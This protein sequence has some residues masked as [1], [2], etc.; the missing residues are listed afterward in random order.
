MP[1]WPRADILALLGVVITVVVAL[2]PSV[3]RA[4]RGTAHRAYVQCGFPRRRYQRWFVKTYRTVY[5]VYLDRREELDLGQVY[6]SLSVSSGRDGVASRTVATKILGAP[7]MSRLLVIGDPGSGKSTLLKAYG[8]GSSRS[9]RGLEGTELR[10]VHRSKQVAFFVPLRH[11]AKD[12]HEVGFDLYRY[13]VTEILVRNTGFTPSAAGAFIRYL[14]ERD[15]CVVLLDGLDEVPTDR[16][17]TIRDAI[18]RF[19]GDQT[20]SCP[21]AHSRIVLTCRRQNFLTMA[22]EWTPAFVDHSHA[23]SPFRDA[24]IFRY[25]QN[26]R[27]TF[28][29]PQSPET[30]LNAVVA[31]GTL[32]LHRIPLILAMS[33]GLF[34]SRRTEEVPGSRALLYRAMTTELL[35]RHNFPTDPVTKANEFKVKDKYRFLREFA[36]QMAQRENA[37]QDFTRA[38]ILKAATEIRQRL[39][40]VDEDRIA[41]MVQEIIKRAGLLTSVSEEGAFTFAHRSIQEYLAAEE[42]QRD[43]A[44]GMNF[45]LAKAPDPEWRQV[46]LFF[47]SGDQS[48]LDEFLDRLLT[49]NAEL[50]AHCLADADASD[51]VAAKIVAHIRDSAT[52]HSSLPALLSATLSPRRAI[53]EVAVGAIQEIL[54]SQSGLAAQLGGEIDGSIKVLEAL[55]SANAA[56][57][58]ALVPVLAAAIPDDPRLVPVLWRCLTAPGIEQLPECREIVIRLLDLTVD[59]VF[60]AELQRQLPFDREFITPELRRRAYPFNRSLPHDANMVTLLAWAEYLQV[61]PRR[62]TRFFE[63]KQAEPGA[64]NSIES[65][66][67]KTLRVRPFWPARITSAVAPLTCLT[68]IVIQL[69]I[70]SHVYLQ[71]FGGWS[72]ILFASPALIGIG[73]ALL[74]DYISNSSRLGKLIELSYDNRTGSVTFQL[75]D[76]V[77]DWISKPKALGRLCFYATVF[78]PSALYGFALAPIAT[79]SVLYFLVLSVAAV[80]VCWFVPMMRICDPDSTLYLYRPNPY[81]DVYQEPTSRHW[82][83]GT[84]GGQAP[85][86][87]LNS[88]AVRSFEN[89]A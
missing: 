37:F 85:S 35:G 87:D 25:L 24:E 5:N 44:A 84:S 59:P 22:D 20:P 79:T 32:D 47:A 65:S 6:V 89:I 56:K 68:A 41:D 62:R 14:L 23:L 34:L 7:D 13:V 55:A 72:I 4:I 9:M 30:F 31:S 57:I 82:L 66:L 8:V 2:I 52:D 88:L 75:S 18:Y 76:A 27:S 28:K 49:V 3:R 1:D 71:P 60:F 46:I 58:A 50:A 53:R 29:P 83:N 39:D 33:V 42:L 67:R 12:L 21:T 17:A 73:L 11:F 69:R 26:L 70:N 54:T 19:A 77:D 43:Y 78:C 61:K 80:V 36:L 16:I 64:F 51:E 74:S 86:T 40:D 63:A 48:Q 45:L 38:D 10:T 15:Q 81:V